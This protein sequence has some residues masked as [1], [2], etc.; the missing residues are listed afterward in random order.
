MEALARS[1]EKLAFDVMIRG[2]Y[3]AKAENFN[4]TNVT[5]LVGAWRQ[6]SSMT[7]NQFGIT[8]WTDFDYSWLVD[9]WRVRRTAREYKFIDAFK[10]RSFFQYPYKFY[11]ARS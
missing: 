8:N 5:G 2:L 11:L 9:P 3:I 4:I 1:R 10:R 6:F 7:L